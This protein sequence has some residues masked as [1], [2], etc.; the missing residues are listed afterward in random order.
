MPL[1][2]QRAVLAAKVEAVE[3]T[4]ETLLAANGILALSAQF[5]RNQDL[6]ARDPLRP[7]L[8]QLTSV[9]GRRTAT[10]T[11]TCE[12]KG[13]GTAGTVPEW[14]P[15]MRSCGFGE[16]I[17][18]VTSVTYAPIS[19]GD[20][21]ITEALYMDGVKRQIAGARSTLSFGGAVG[22]FCIMNFTTLGIDDTTS[23]TAIIAPTY[24]TTVPKALKGL[25]FTLHGSTV[26]CSAFSFD[27][28]ITNTPRGDLTKASGFAS[29]F[30]GNRL[31]VCNFVVETPLVASK[32]W[33][34]IMDAGTEA[35]INL[36]ISLAAGNIITITS[37]KF[38]V[39]NITEQDDG[40]IAKL[41]LDGKLNLTTGDDE[42]SI[43][44][45]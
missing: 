6:L 44:L 2:T 18:A 32:D 4:P 34:G 25:T 23:D 7:T 39:T 27:L 30:F 41:S 43:A 5:Q 12:M 10:I 28:G 20:V 31:P 29:V 33:Y 36:V 1:R 3:G 19:T 24:Q 35:N 15:L 21:S 11:A 16:T 9:P 42:L 38:Q 14:G 37:A 17:V 8:S 40:G 26:V 13:S 45:T 22:E